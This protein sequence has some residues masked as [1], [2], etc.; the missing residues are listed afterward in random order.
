MLF[1]LNREFSHVIDTGGTTMYYQSCVNM[2]SGSESH[3]WIV[4]ALCD[5]FEW[6]VELHCKLLDTPGFVEYTCINLIYC[7]ADRIASG[8]DVVREGIHIYSVIVSN[9][10]LSLLEKVSKTAYCKY[11]SKRCTSLL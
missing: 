5:A 3:K 2:N 1:K 6:E 4:I 7:S 10:F 11:I 9:K 8:I